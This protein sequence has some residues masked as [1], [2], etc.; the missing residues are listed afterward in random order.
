MGMPRGRPCASRQLA[1][2]LASG[3]TRRTVRGARPVVGWRSIRL[4][5][6]TSGHVSAACSRSGPRA[7]VREAG[8]DRR[9]AQVQL[10]ADRLGLA[11][12]QD[13][14]DVLSHDR[15][16]GDRLDRISR[17]SSPLDRVGEHALQ[18]AERLADRR[19]AD[20]VALEVGGQG[21][22]PLRAQLAQLVAADSGQQMAFREHLVAP[23][24]RVSEV[25]DGVGAP[26]LLDD[27]ARVSLPR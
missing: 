2:S 20:A 14:H 27:A 12:C 17:D 25:R 10:G 4:W 5:S 16:L 19:L 15:R 13:P 24:R 26:P 18:H 11:R 6:S 1:R 23:K 8:D 22:D 9:V 3:A 7:R 21:D